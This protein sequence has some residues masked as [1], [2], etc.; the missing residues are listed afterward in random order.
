MSAFM[1]LCQQLSNGSVNLIQEA[2]SVIIAAEE[3]LELERRAVVRL[4]AVFRRWATRRAYRHTIK[5]VMRIQRV[6]RG[7]KDRCKT[8]QKVLE[9]RAHAERRVYHHCAT[10]VQSRVRGFLTR[11]KVADFY[12]QKRYLTMVEM[13][14]QAV[15]ATAKEHAAMQQQVEENKMKEETRRRFEAT[16]PEPRIGVPT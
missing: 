1:R 8:L 3:S 2:F 5:I 12:K 4:Q 10:V 7:Y 13:R 16:A 6:Y 14:S 9:H 15:L 11:L